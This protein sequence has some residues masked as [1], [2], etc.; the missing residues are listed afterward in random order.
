MNYSSE[1]KF[2][3]QVLSQPKLG[4]ISSRGH[5]VLPVWDLI[6]EQYPVQAEIIRKA[7]IENEEKMNDESERWRLAVSEN[8]LNLKLK[9]LN[10]GSN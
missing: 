10:M 6:K 7:W 2:I 1:D 9:L 5:Q 4:R 8:V 3:K